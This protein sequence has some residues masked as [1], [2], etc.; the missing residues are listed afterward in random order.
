MQHFM[1]HFIGIPI[2]LSLFGYS[3]L[4]TGNNKLDLWHEST[5]LI[6][7]NIGIGTELAVDL[8]PAQPIV[9]YGYLFGYYRVNKR[10]RVMI[11]KDYEGQPVFGAS[12]NWEIKK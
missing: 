10:L 1:K 5:V 3:T 4:W 11:G 2:I 6:Y 12:L 8:M 7:K 9:V